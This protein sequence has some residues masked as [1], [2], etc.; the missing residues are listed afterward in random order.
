VAVVEVRELTKKYGKLEAL[1]EVS[2][3]VGEGEIFGLLGRNGAGKTTLVKIL[4]GIV[5]PT[6]GQAELLGQRYDSASVRRRIGYLPEDHRLP[7]YHTGNSFLLT[8][9]LIHGMSPSQ[10]KER[11]TRMLEM[12]G[13]SDWGEAKIGT[14]SKGMRQRLGLAQAMM[15]DPQL[16][17]LDEPTDGVDPVGRREI[18]DIILKLK[19]E[20]KTVF[21][22][23]HLLSEVEVTCDRVAIIETGKLVREGTVAE[24]TKIENRYELKLVGQV[25][26]LIGDLMNVVEWARPM[27]G[28]MEVQVEDPRQIDKVIDFLRSRNIGIRG[29]V[30]KTNKLEDVFLKTV[31]EPRG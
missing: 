7:D 25:Q 4:L 28:G 20:G 16:V 11:G 27:E 2:L 31:R 12:M 21:I 15:H 17:F 10:V 6:H 8:T 3:S 9:G 1:K 26:D 14:F 30:A 22:N 19:D 23:S 24:M 18:R 29:L 5:W 13:L